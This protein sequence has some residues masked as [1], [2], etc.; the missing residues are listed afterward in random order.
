MVGNA[1]LHQERGYDVRGGGWIEMLMHDVRYGVRTLRANP[2]FTI[3]ATLTLA[4]GIGANT[5]IFSVASGVLMRPLPY[6]AADELSMI[7]MDNARIQLREDW[8]SYPGFDE[9]RRLSSTFADM[10]IFNGRSTTLTDGSGGDPERVIGAHGSANLF[11]L[12]GVPP[13]RGRGFAWEED[14]PGANNVVVISHALWQRRFG[15]RTD[16]LDSTVLINTRPMRIIGVMPEGFAFP[17]VTTEFWVPTAPTDQQ[18]TNGGSLWLQVI[19]RRKPGVSVAQAQSD[20][21][22]LADERVRR[23]PGQKGYGVYV[24]DYR[25]QIVGRVRPAILVLLGAVGFVLLIACTN[26]ANL[27]MA[28]A[29][30]RERELALRSAIGADR[31]R[32]IRQLLTESLLLSAIGGVAGMSLAWLGLRALIR[33]APADL[34]RLSAIAI[35]TPVLVFT[36]LVVIATGVLFGLL[37]AVQAARSSVVPTLKEGGRG[38][39][40]AGRGL[41][42]A[43][44][45]LEVALAVVLLVGAGLMIRSFVKLQQVDLGFAP[46]QVL[47]ARVAL[48]GER[49]R[50][51]PAV[52]DFF[53]QLMDK[54]NAAPGVEGAAGVGTVFLSATPNSTNFSIE[55]RPDFAPEDA[56]EVPVDAVTPTY[57]KVMRVPLR[58]GRFFDARDSAEA[59]RTV[60]INETM[61]RRFWPNEDPIGRRIAYGSS[62]P[63]ARWM[64]IVGVVADTRRTG[65]ESV[66][67]PETYLPHAQSPSGGMMLVIRSAGD[68]QSAAPALRAAV[69]D[70]DTTVALQGVRPITDLLVDMTAQRRLNTVLLAVFGVV[71]GLLA[72]V[73][74]YGVLAYSVEARTREMGVRVA[75]GAS[76]ASILALVLREGLMLAGIGLVLGLAGALA[77]TRTMRTLVYQVST[78]DP[79]TFAV[80]AAVAATVSLAA[81]L[82]PAWRAVRVDP[83]LALRAD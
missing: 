50:E 33:L 58:R 30:A 11:T 43:L 27:L 64:E 54:L 80:I 59:P 21:G 31:A 44:V 57:F 77:L 3:V 1:L 48:Y 32:L 76:R 61:A 45:T 5:A 56:V 67:R 78:V 81:C 4:L 8:H 51:A 65:Y 16:I 46:D 49:Y 24:V 36:A 69:R 35:D 53:G 71:A 25:E 47:S 7:W 2:A 37:P 28:R 26:V 38:A 15:G 68:A 34:P 70:L 79:A 10:A 55:G 29:S 42:R 62:N 74:I 52:V 13:A 63:N 60:I 20:L 19:G 41:R 75:L 40:A 22:R 18:R 39:T 82:I 73:G 66:V 72:A 23:D 17:S 6:R 83:I 12:L 14:R 9:Y